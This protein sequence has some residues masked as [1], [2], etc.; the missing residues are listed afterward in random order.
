[1]PSE[2]MYR[3][4]SLTR[5]LR[6]GTRRELAWM[7]LGW[8]GLLL[9]SVGLG[10]VAVIFEWSGLPLRFGGVEVY[11]TIYP[12]L[13]ICLLLAL[14]FGWW[15]GA[16][17]AYLATFTLALYA[18]MPLP[19]AVLFACADPLYFAVMAIGYRAIP[20]AR[21]LRDPGAVMFFVQ[22][23]FVASIFSSSGALIWWYTNGIDR[24]ELLPIWQGWW[25]GAFLQSV[26]LV[27][28]LMALLWPRLSR[29][30][31]ARP[32]LLAPAAR[33]GRRSVLYLLGAVTAGV[34]AYG[35]LTLDL[36]GAQLA[37]AAQGANEAVSQAAT[38]MRQTSW[39]FFWVFALIILF[40][41]FFGY[42]LFS[43]WQQANDRLLAELHG[44]NRALDALAHTDALSG[45]LNRRAIDVRM[46][47]EW[48]RAARTGAGGAL[49]M[50]DIDHFKRINDAFGHPAG[51]AV[52]RRV[53]EAIR[54]VMRGMDVA[55][56]YGGEEFVVLLPQ[57]DAQGAWQFAERLRAQIEPWPLSVGDGQIRF[58]VSLG[59]AAF[60]PDDRG[61]EAWLARADRALYRAK[62]EGRNRTVMA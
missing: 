10:L 38:V 24:T 7:A 27:G 40:I 13:L 18:G 59:V 42:R 60:A 17:P 31:A 30:L 51:D 44:A 21:D 47:N 9:A 33:D 35:F 55:G 26:V 61:H 37:Q 14:A 57:T 34:L 39:V 19:W 8:S 25:L 45:L 36:A 11:I 20:A 23:S 50:L 15:W 49:V 5:A 46:E 22:L 6:H 3:A 2:P 43:H 48:H 41:A 1:M 12:P 56:R 53:A 62:Q 54:G 58:T 16:I 29:W 4:V 32:E 52:I 28:P